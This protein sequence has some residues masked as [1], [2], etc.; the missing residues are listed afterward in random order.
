MIIL[1]ENLG[2]WHGENYLLS[3][4]VQLIYGKLGTEKVSKLGC[5]AAE[6]MALLEHSK[7]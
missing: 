6:R 7:M 2:L 3:K 5:H 4:S 1:K